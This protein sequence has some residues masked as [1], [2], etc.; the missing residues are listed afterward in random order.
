MNDEQLEAAILAIKPKDAR[1][2]EVIHDSGNIFGK[3]WDVS[4][5]WDGDNVTEFGATLAE[6]RNKAEVSMRRKRDENKRRA[7]VAL[8]YA[9]DMGLTARDRSEA[10]E[11]TW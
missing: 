7:G 1:R 6:A 2:I 8:A 4:L 10:E 5:F 11:M 3:P 9:R